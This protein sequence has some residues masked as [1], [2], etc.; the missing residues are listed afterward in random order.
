MGQF[1]R[2]GTHISPTC[3]GLKALS[4]SLENRLSFFA[5]TCPAAAALYA[6]AP[7]FATLLSMAPLDSVGH[8]SAH[9]KQRHSK[10]YLAWSLTRSPTSAF[11]KTPE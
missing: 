2:V 8:S 6:S 1:S 9:A 7:S 11:E 4:A 5:S 10:W 3:V